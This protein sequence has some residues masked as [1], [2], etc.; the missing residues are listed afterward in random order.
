[1]VRP[2]EDP[3]GNVNEDL[4]SSH[5]M[6][7]GRIGISGLSFLILGMGRR[8]CQRRKPKKEGSHRD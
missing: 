8:T 1:V 5:S 3:E 4:S 7:R 6:V 2:K